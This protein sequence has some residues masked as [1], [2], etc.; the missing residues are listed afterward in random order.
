VNVSAPSRRPG[1]AWARFRRALGFLGAGVAITLLLAWGVP[2]LLSLRGIGPQANPAPL[3]LASVGPDSPPAWAGPALVASRGIFSDSIRATRT[4]A[5]AWPTPP[6][7]RFSSVHQAPA[8]RDL[9]GAWSRMDS[10]PTGWS[11]APDPAEDP[12]RWHTIWSTLT[13]LPFRCFAGEARHPRADGEGPCVV[14]GAAEVGRLMG[15]PVLLPLRPLAVG[16]ALD[17]A[18]WS[19][20]AWSAV[21]FPAA[22][23]RRRREKHGRCGSCGHELDPHATSRPERCPECAAELPKDPLGFARSPEMHFQ[24]H[25]VWLVFFSSLDVMLTWKILEQG[26]REI[27]PIAAAV[28]DFWGMHGATAFKFALIT[29]VVIVCEVLARMRA[30]AGRFLAVAAVAISAFPVCWSLTLLVLHRLLPQ[31]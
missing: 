9:H 31:A 4:E 12:Q 23:R 27:N 14:L 15:E 11:V 7:E 28:I 13:G 10:V 19:A 1:M 2:V 29:W 24:N 30:R 25:Y 6:F 22:W 18:V 5:G 26:G 3:Q 21:A 16:L 17:V 20:V 8:P